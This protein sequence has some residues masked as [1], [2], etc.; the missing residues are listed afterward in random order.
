MFTLSEFNLAREKC[1]DDMR[2][3]FEALNIPFPGWEKI[4][5]N[6]QEWDREITRRVCEVMGSATISEGYARLLNAADIRY[7][8]G[9]PDEMLSSI[10]ARKA[11][12]IDAVT[13]SAHTFRV[14]P[15]REK[16]LDGLRKLMDYLVSEASIDKNPSFNKLLSKHPKLW[17]AMS[18]LRN[19]A[20]KL[21]ASVYVK[22]EQSSQQAKSINDL[23]TGEPV[24]IYDAPSSD[25]R[26]TREAVLRILAVLEIVDE[27]KRKI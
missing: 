10:T 23:P 14:C 3:L 13:K 6:P 8:L 22:Q 17:Q 21:P 20:A 4:T 25:S 15:L 7:R 2:E 27:I 19:E 12:I 18:I 5:L 24:V 11:E 1:P 26:F 16:S 9:N